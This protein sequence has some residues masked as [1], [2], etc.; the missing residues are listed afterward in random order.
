[1]DVAAPGNSCEGLPARLLSHHGG[2]VAGTLAPTG[3]SGQEDDSSN[4]EH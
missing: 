2:E 1:M 4:V 3:S